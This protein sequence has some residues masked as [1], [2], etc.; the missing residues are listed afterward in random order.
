MSIRDD[1]SPGGAL[2]LTLD[3]YEPREQQIEMAEA[4]AHA[5]EHNE[6]LLIEAGTGTG[7]TLAYLLPAVRSK[8]R[9]MVSTAT[10]TLQ[11]QLIE[12]DIPLLQSIVGPVDAVLLKGRQNYLC[13]SQFERF[14]EEPSFRS[15][16]EEILWPRLREWAEN[17]DTGDR[18]E[19]R[20]FNEDMPLWQRVSSTADQ[21]AGRD[22]PDFAECYLFDA[23]ERAESADIVVVN[24]HLFFADAAVQDRRDMRLLPEVEGLIFDEGHH[25]EETA[26]SFF[27][28]HVSNRSLERLLDDIHEHLLSGQSV[29]DL[30]V[31]VRST[32]ELEDRLNFVRTES[33]TFFNA[34]RVLLTTQ[35]QGAKAGGGSGKRLRLKQ[36]RINTSAQSDADEIRAELHA[37]LSSDTDDI[38]EELETFTE[39]GI[40]LREAMKALRITLQKLFAEASTRS[41]ERLSAWADDLQHI[42]AHEA[43]THIYLV[44]AR[45]KTIALEAIPL[46]VRPIFWRHVFGH[47]GATVVTSAT[48]ATDGNLRYL[49]ARLGA[50]KDTVERTLESPFN[51]MKQALLYVPSKIPPPNDPR[52]VEA[53]ADEI[54][55]L[56]EITDGRAFVLFTSYRNMHYAHQLLARRWDWKT[57]M[58]GQMS[59]GRLL[60]IFREDGNAVLFATASFW[61]GVDVPG[62]ALSLVIMDKLPFANPR[63]PLVSARNRDVERSGGNA[64]RDYTIPQTIIRLKQGFGRLIRAKN[65]VGIVAIMDTRVIEKSYGSRIVKS[66][67]RARRSRDIELAKRWWAHVTSSERD[68]SSE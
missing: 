64:F 16:E 9:V 10:K 44:T 40:A 50:P 57:L 66:L 21:C 31:G 2:D 46:D 51:Y 59:R 7:K 25:L 30:N 58:Q 56:V 23:R 17:T 53:M 37:V 15:S 24:H 28:V 33:D 54:E 55:R 12:K 29:L 45:H 41:R 35:Q 52:F 19:L 13:I 39:Q 11:H 8:R 38:S 22:C 49:R 43:D 68:P 47:R 3:A 14:K 18:A 32:Q 48:L 63:D 5:L 36:T 6:K 67:P 20:D 60:E 1:F 61:E 4:V 62:D 27:T 34:L 65:D 26:S 42:L